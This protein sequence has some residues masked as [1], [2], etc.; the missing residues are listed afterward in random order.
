MKVSIVALILAS[1]VAVAAAASA[2]LRREETRQLSEVTMP[3]DIQGKPQGVKIDWDRGLEGKKKRKKKKKKDPNA[4]KRAT[5]KVDLGP[6]LMKQPAS[7]GVAATVSTL[8]A[9]V[10]TMFGW[11]EL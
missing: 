3:Q 5:S 11:L 8:T 10:P 1:P 6:V 4:P 7:L 2:N 9:V